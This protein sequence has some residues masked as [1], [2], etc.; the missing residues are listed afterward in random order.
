MDIHVRRTIFPRPPTPIRHAPRN[1]T[2]AI[3]AL[4]IRGGNRALCSLWW[5]YFQCSKFLIIWY[6][7]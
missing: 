5:W 3:T 7:C 4:R 2:L 6:G 1:S